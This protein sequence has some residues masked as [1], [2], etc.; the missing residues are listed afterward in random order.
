MKRTLQLTSP[1]MHGPDVAYARR[2]LANHGYSSGLKQGLD[3]FDGAAAAASKRAKWE[4][5]YADKNCTPTFGSVL[6]QYLLQVREPS[7]V[8]KTRARSRRAQKTVGQKAVAE[9]KRWVGTREFPA[10]TNICKPFTTWYGWIGWGAPWCAVFVSYCL[11][12]AG[13]KGVSPANHRWAYCPTVVAD[14]V[15]G[16]YGLSTCSEHEVDE[17]TIVLFDW[18]ND[19]VADHIGFCT[20]PIE[21]ST[22]TFPTI[23]GNTSP[24]ISGSQSNGGGVYE[25]TRHLNDAILFVHAG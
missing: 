18:D 9:A 23:E 3:V 10:N 16:R 20:G 8:M 19:G 1:L 6:E 15:A 14:A 22:Q 13:F 5:G 24:G 11:A 4:L 12:K 25:R 2:V 17:G 21:F 7:L